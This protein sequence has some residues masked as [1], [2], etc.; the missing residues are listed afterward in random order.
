VIFE[1]GGFILDATKRELTGPDGAVDVPSRAFDV[2]LYLVGH[3]GELL[4]KTAIMKAVWPATVVEEGNLSRCI[5][6]LRR[7]LGDTASEARF[8]ATVPGRGYQFVKPVRKSSPETAAGEIAAGRPRWLLPVGAVVAISFALLIAWRFGPVS[9]ST[10]S[11]D[12][13][14][15]L[16][17]ATI[18]VV[19]FADMTST[20]DMEY[21]SEGLAEELRNSLSKVRALRVIGRQS[22]NAFT[23]KGVDTKSIGEKLHVAAILE[24]SVRKEGDRIDIKVHLIRARDG[25]MLWSEM[26][27]RQFDDVLDIQGS[28]ARE[29]A[30]T[31]APAVRD[32]QGSGLPGSFDA[33]LTRDAEAYRAYL[34][35][36]YL[37]SRWT[38]HDPQPARIEFQRAVERDP[39]FA[40]AWAM[41]AR[42]HQ[43]SA[44]LGIGDVA[45]Q[46]SLATTTLD[47]ALKLDP[48]IGDLWWVKLIFS[49]KD[50]PPFAVDVADL[51]RAVAENPTDTEPML[52][53]AH[54]YLALARRDD[55]LQMFERAYSAD[56]L[57]PNAIWSNAW[58]G[59][60]F[61]GDRKRLLDLV[62]EMERLAPNDAKPSWTRSDLA[63]IEGRTLDWDRFVTRVIEVDPADHQNH[64]WLA[65]GY[66][67]L[68]A[69]DAALYHA[70]MCSKLEPL[71][72]TCAYSTSHAQVLSGDLASARKTVLEAETR[73]PQNALIQTARGEL[74]FFS[75]D[76]AGALQSVSRSHP[77]FLEPEKDLDLLHYNDDVAMVAWCLRERGDSARV[78]EMTRVFNRQYAPPVTAGMF[79][80][81]RARM[82]AAT[83]D[84]SALVNHLKALV[85]T[86]S[87][88]LVFVKHDPM[89]MPWLRDP[90]IVALLDELEAR[91]AEWR[92]VLPRASTRVAV[93]GVSGHAGS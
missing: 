44:T 92:R 86:H 35:G 93:P 3:P 90:E 4:D 34:R 46:R 73:D 20:K 36:V 87:P 28:I 88:E 23:G 30:A 54:T 55:A 62:G 68:G 56:P 17:P 42:T 75:G 49:S 27:L 74:Q 78:A 29:V 7:A 5:F 57:S 65:L 60:V 70:K 79:E 91:R 51:E 72:A 89:I 1:F 38:D 9:E 37:F 25:V 40:K 32:S 71:A 67:R 12:Y 47:K 53:L 64:A 80:I 77:G 52:W 82:A 58:F 45:R 19:P 22:S 43:L 41:L 48:A 31:L 66:I 18:A 16:V 33:M 83:G 11:T 39:Q 8:I 85:N 61:T 81:W 59:Y 76:C 6:E 14:P 69:F 84:R 21:F 26:Y 63:L 13:P 24:G 10:G 2:L 15:D 50:Y